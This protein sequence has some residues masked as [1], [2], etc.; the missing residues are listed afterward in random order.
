M[1]HTPGPWRVSLCQCENPGC[2]RR[3]LAGDGTVIASRISEGPNATL[4]AAAPEL[5]DALRAVVS[6]YRTFR[7]VP[8]REQ[9]W[10]RIDDE[11]IGAAQIA[12][13]KAEG[14]IL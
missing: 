13:A 3:I 2:I 8:H 5:L 7:N 1:N 11:A 4:A 14:K 6:T 10:T 12:I 9:E